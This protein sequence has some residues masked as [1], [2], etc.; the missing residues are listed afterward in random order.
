MSSDAFGQRWWGRVTARL[1]RGARRTLVGRLLWLHLFWAVAV[2]VIAITALWW[3][4]ASLIEDSLRK[5]AVQWIDE[6]DALG[7][8]L[9]AAADRRALVQIEARVRNF[10]EIAA[11]RYYDASGKRLLGEYRRD[12]SMTLPALDAKQIESLAAQKGTERPLLYSE[13]S[14]AFVWM[15]VIAPVRVRSIR[16]DGLFDF[17]LDQPANERVRVIGYLDIAMEPAVYR[18]Q[19]W[20]NILFG[21]VL[22]AL[23]VVA[24]LFVGRFFIRRALAPLTRLQQ[25]LERLARGD[26]DVEVESGGDA[27]IAAIGGALRAT[28]SALRERDQTLRRLADHDTLTGLVNRA[29]FARELKEEIE[30]VA[31]ER[32]RSAV[33]FLDL[34]HFKVV[35]DTL[36]HAAGDRL[37]LQVTERFRA[38]LRPGDLL[39]RFGGDEFTVLARDVDAAG[40][41]EL[42]Q[43]LLR[44]MQDFRFIE[45]DQH[46]TVYCSIGVALLDSERFSA[47]DLVAQADIACYEAKARGRNRFHFYELADHERSRLAADV[48]WSRAIQEAIS[49]DRFELA[50]Q[51]IV[52]VKGRAREFYEVLLRLPIGDELALPASFLPAAERYG[53]ITG[54]DHWVVRQ[55]L[56]RLGEWRRSGRDLSFSINLS[57]AS[58][59]DPAL[60]TLIREEM[61]RNGVPPSSMVFEITEQTAVRHLQ[62]AGELIE[63]LRRLGCGFA[64]DDFGSGFSAFGYLKR[65]P[66]DYI[67]LGAPFV[68]EIVHDL[69]NQAIVRSIVQVA[70]ALGKQTIAEQ[71]E[72]EATYAVLRS[73]GVDYIQGYYSGAAAVAL[74]ERAVVAFRPRVVGGPAA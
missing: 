64:L 39:C 29:Y 27:E 4:S 17:R 25:P 74:P 12:M 40:A 33:L 24:A 13:P 34:D 54:I 55:A 2:Y 62:K 11:V 68:P 46:F 30:R 59:D 5:Q 6:L 66:A 9:F 42:A 23:L 67:K 36:G 3:T 31:R 14:R 18:E 73:C 47:E 56:R 69:H 53:L 1:A 8:P 28:V 7:T 43:S 45:N 61:E 16:S 49:A 51:P 19:L 65:L 44:G 60:L 72:D 41:Q 32:A 35:N 71:V 63:T 22:V 52:S 15:R 38:V 57:G 26:I 10:P 50:Y 37:L 20:R 48:N 58:L 21:S 70:Q